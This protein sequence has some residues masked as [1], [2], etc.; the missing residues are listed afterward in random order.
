[1]DL[2]DRGSMTSVVL[3]SMEGGLEQEDQQEKDTAFMPW[4][5]ES[6]STLL[7]VFC[8]CFLMGEGIKKAVGTPPSLSMIT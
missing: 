8:V 3:Q 5:L 6:V 2:H 4:G 7:W 1:M